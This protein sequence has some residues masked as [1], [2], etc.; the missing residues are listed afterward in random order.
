M[1]LLRRRCR[2]LFFFSNKRVR[3]CNPFADLRKI[4]YW[5]VLIYFNSEKKKL[6]IMMICCYILT[7]SSSLV[8][9]KIHKKKNDEQDYTK[10][11]VFNIKTLNFPGVNG[12]GARWIYAIGFKGNRKRK[13]RSLLHQDIPKNSITDIKQS[14]SGKKKS[15]KKSKPKSFLI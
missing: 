6:K 11:V 15:K 10:R 2:R 1:F 3:F 12:S 5:F 14:K 13:I 8:S 4:K 7:Y 9:L